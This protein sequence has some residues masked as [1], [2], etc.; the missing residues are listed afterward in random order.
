MKTFI[1][2]TLCWTVLSQT[3]FASDTP[4]KRHVID[5]SSQGADGI[6]TADINGDGLLDLT[7]GWEEGG[8][9][10]V[11][12]NPGAGKAREPWP[13]VTV[14]RVKSPEDAVFADLDDDGNIDVVSSCEGNT[15]GV[16]VHWAPSRDHLLEESAWKTEA[17]PALANKTRW[18]FCLPLQIDGR[19][20]I[21][22]VLGSKEPNAVVGWLQ[23]PIEN[24]RELSG[25]KWHE[26]Y[27]AGWIMS[28]FP[29]TGP[30]DGRVDPRTDDP[31]GTSFL[32]TDRKG[33][34]RGLY[35]FEHPGFHAV[36]QNEKWNI[37]RL[38]GEDHEV[39]FL[40]HR[41][42]PAPG[43]ETIIATRD[44]GILGFA[45]NDTPAPGD[46]K[47]ARLRQTGTIPTA[48]NTGTLK[49]VRWCDVDL[50]TRLDLIYSC[51]N[52]TGDKSGV[53]WLKHTERASRNPWQR[54]EIS[55]PEGVKFD[56]I[57]LIDLDA[58]GDLDVLTCEERTNLGVIWYENPT[59]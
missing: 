43:W 52:A 26:L 45:Q 24:P 30:G 36:Q 16:F 32:V 4:W 14:G 5:N 58:D 6:R 48:E 54:N 56:L 51:E 23:A 33:P 31:V 59:R 13:A 8:V 11:Y 12:L 37:Q 55:G 22:L 57:Q 9:I 21:D 2:S 40:D 34:T 53:V 25:W 17:I 50:D 20:G 47:A 18:M 27:K 38:G 46:K 41:A 49:S 44:N 1:V 19:R 3:L 42:I 35:L 7:T 29:L 39:M 15:K 28:I 10:R